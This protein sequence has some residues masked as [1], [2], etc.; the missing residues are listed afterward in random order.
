M[1]REMVASDL[2]EFKKQEILTKHGYE[3]IDAKE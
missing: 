3:M 2:E 1:C